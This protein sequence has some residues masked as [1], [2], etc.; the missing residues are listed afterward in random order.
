MGLPGDWNAH[1]RLGAITAALVV[2][3]QLALFG[4]MQHLGQQIAVISSR[5]AVQHQLLRR[6]ILTVL[7]P[8]ER[9]LSRGANSLLPR[10]GNGLRHVARSARREVSLV[11]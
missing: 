2:E 9:A 8:V 1:V 6:I 7:C 11:R 3:D 4:E 5:T 10:R